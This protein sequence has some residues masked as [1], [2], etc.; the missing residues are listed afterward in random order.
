MKLQ[1]K[2]WGL[3]L[4]IFGILT[5]SGIAV[6]NHVI[7]GRF[8]ELEKNQSQIEG[9]RA[10]R[11]LEQQHQNLSASL[12]DYAYWA[13]T[14]AYIGEGMP[15][16]IEEHFTVE[17][18][19]SLRISELLFMDLQGRAVAGVTFDTGVEVGPLDQERAQL[20][21]SLAL[22]AL[23]DLT[24]ETVVESFANAKGKLY[25]ISVAA[26]REDATKGSPPLGAMAMVREFDQRELVKFS[27]ILMHP[28]SLMLE[29]LC[30]EDEPLHAVFHGDLDV[31]MHASIRDH[32]SKP[33]GEL[34]LR[35]D[36]TLYQQGKSFAQATGVAVALTGLLMGVLLVFLLDR[37]LLRR[38][39]GFHRDHGPRPY[40]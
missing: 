6:S 18:M 39:Q 7:S 14:V 23:Q 40:G 32:N 36:R 2:A 28:V 31:A 34:V 22:P 11:L 3:V 27:R 29:D 10:Q 16:Y 12:K 25:L 35:L 5:A 4:A 20:L 13:D 15:G 37:L 33:V 30:P 19:S 17:T 8:A 21:S 26:V 9:L 1:F 38:L 24:G